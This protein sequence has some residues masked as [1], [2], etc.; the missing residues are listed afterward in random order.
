MTLN[1]IKKEAAKMLESGSPLAEVRQTLYSKYKDMFISARDY[2]NKIGRY[3]R[4]Y[5]NL[6][7]ELQRTAHRAC[8]EGTPIVNTVN[9]KHE[10]TKI[11]FEKNGEI[12]A[13]IN[14]PAGTYVTP[15]DILKAVNLSPD[16]FTLTSVKKSCWDAQVKGGDIVKMESIRVSCKN[17][18][19][20]LTREEAYQAVQNAINRGRKYVNYQPVT[21]YSNGE[22]NQKLGVLQICDCHFGAICT[23][24]EHGIEWGPKECKEDLEF[25][26]DNAIRA[27]QEQPVDALIIAMTGDALNSDTTTHTTAHGTPQ[28]DGML[29]YSELVKD[30]FYIMCEVIDKLSN[31]LEIPINVLHTVGNHDTKT[32]YD[33][34]MMLRIKYDNNPNVIIL[35]ELNKRKYR[36]YGANLLMFT[37][38]Q[39]EGKRVVNAPLNE[40]PAAVG[41]TKVT[42]IISEHTHQYKLTS[43]GRTVHIVGSTIAPPGTWTKDNAYVGGRRGGQLLIFDKKYCL[44]TQQFL[45]VLHDDIDEFVVNCENFI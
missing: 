17:I 35:D 38:G 10:K 3:C 23:K 21:A 37:H 22:H 34:I 33:L 30:Y 7:P 6:H 43:D 31:A 42:Y 29:H 13:E 19:G 39:D 1:K 14:A 4:N 16:L 28:F 5:L 41:R 27:L 25:I 11:S 40:A 15:D 12:T 26:T 44:T 32:V 24:R 36:E 9:E 8:A 45:P 2:D 18:A 20:A